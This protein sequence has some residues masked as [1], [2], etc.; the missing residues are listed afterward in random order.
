MFQ[1][2]VLHINKQ[3][4][5][6][7][8][9]F[10]KKLVGKKTR[11]SSVIKGNAYGHGIEVFVPLAEYCG[12]SHFSVFN[13]DEA[14]RAHKASQQKS[15]IMIMGMIDTHELDWAIEND[16]EFF[17]FEFDRLFEAIEAAKRQNKPARIHLE[18]ETG[19][20]RT[21]FD[22]RDAGKVIQVLQNN[23]KYYILEGICT[24]FAGAESIAN[25]AR[26][27]NQQKRYKKYLKQFRRNGLK[28]KYRHVA[29]SAATIAYPDAQLDMVRIG[30]MQYGFWPSPEIF[31]NYISNKEDKSDP[32]DR[33]LT[34]K[35]RVMDTKY[36]K[37]GE[38]ISY[39]TSYM[40]RNNMKIA[41][42]PV[43][44]AHGY[45][46]SLS[47]QGRV[48]INGHRVDIV[49]NVNMNLLIVK[50][51]DIPETK[52]G[53]EVVLIGKQNGSEITVASFSEFSNQLNYEMLTRLP[54]EI[55]R[56]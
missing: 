50:I 2:S 5:I 51:S 37:T 34:W 32:L 47:H 16:I 44:Y 20:N 4:L 53:D 7:N 29:S 36:V 19:M 31:I 13:A 45:S 49:G 52:K 9:E 6:N 11:I 35:S 1:T 25:Y 23:K 8:L 28:P 41:T 38:F 42:I 39:G 30:I 17:V 55:P 21:G 18:M 48:L 3:A 12:I 26:I 33:I 43:G 24:H 15:G 22:E 54:A 56:I 10:I 46:R 27:L 14:L 40:A